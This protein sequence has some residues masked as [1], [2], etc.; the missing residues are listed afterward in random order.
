MAS[1]SAERLDGDFTKL[2]EKVH[3]LDATTTSLRVRES[4]LTGQPAPALRRRRYFP[5]LVLTEGFPV[6]SITLTML[7]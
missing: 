2:L 7:R 1:T 4:A 3:Q 6:N 5:V